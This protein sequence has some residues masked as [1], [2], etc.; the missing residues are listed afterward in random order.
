MRNFSYKLYST[1]KNK[2]L[3][4]MLDTSCVIWNHCV[5]LNNRF[6]SLYGKSIPK[7]KL[8]KHISKLRKKNPYWMNLNSQTVQEIVQRYE[9]A[10]V[11][12]FKGLKKRRP[13]TKSWHKFTSFL[14][15]QSG[16]KVEGNK[17]IISKIGTFKFHKSR[18]YGDI[19]N[20]RIK[21]N[22][23]G[24]LFIIICSKEYIEKPYYRK[25]SDVAPMGMDFGLKMFL[26][27]SDDEEIQSPLFYKKMNKE[28]KK[29]HRNLSKCKKGS[30]NRKKRR[31]ELSR[32]YRRIKHLREDHQWKLAH[33]LCGRYSH[34]FIEDLN[35]EGMKRLWG[36]KVSD[37]CFS[38]FVTKLEHI[39]LKYDTVVHKIDRWFPSTKTCFD[40]GHINH[41]LT[42]R[43]RFWTCPCCGAEHQRDKNSAKNILRKGIF[44]FQRMSNTNCPQLASFA[45]MEES[46]AL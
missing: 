20:V 3:H 33:E 45:C 7:G 38:E 18:D 32:L 26:T 24:D 12:F 44:S 43:D 1:K 15:K 31:G 28:I 10:L 21:R 22:S 9:A 35:I 29:K 37:L 8:D 13:K 30:N 17:I 25:S 46:H 4:Q 39:A 36:R 40:C 34:I 19:R 23:C 42:L 16:Y 41:D 27:T 2:K 5:N 6:Y 11:G 14:F